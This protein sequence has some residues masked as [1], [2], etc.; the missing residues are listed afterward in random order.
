MDNLEGI[1]VTP[2][3]VVCKEEAFHSGTFEVILQA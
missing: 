1:K 3:R 2:C